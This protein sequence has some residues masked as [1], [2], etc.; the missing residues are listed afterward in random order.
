MAETCSF[1]SPQEAETAFYDAFECADIDAM[2]AVWAPDDSVVCIHPGGS[3]LEGVEAVKESWQDIFTSGE[4]L[5]FNITD[6]HCTQGNLL[7]IHIVRENIQIDNV[8]QGVMLATN[9]YQF[10]GGG[11]RMMLHHASPDPQIEAQ[12]HDEEMRIL[13]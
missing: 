12:E 8:I 7:A 2:M 4:R 6:R 10:I 11:W 3:R 13:H 5:K 1:A 9:I